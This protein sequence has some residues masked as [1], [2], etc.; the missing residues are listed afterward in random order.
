MVDLPELPVKL[1]RLE[2]MA[3]RLGG[4]P[5]QARPIEA[6]WEVIAQGGDLGFM[7]LEQLLA[8]PDWT[9]A[10]ATRLW[11][12]SV[13]QPPIKGA[14]RWKLAL[15]LA[16]L[17]PEFPPLL[18]QSAPLDSPLSEMLSGDTQKILQ[19]G[20]ANH[21]T[22]SEMFRRAGLPGKLPFIQ[23]A[24][25]DAASIFVQ[26][27]RA[28][29]QMAGASPESRQ[30]W[31]LGCLKPLEGDRVIDAVEILLRGI[32]ARDAAELPRM[33]NW[34]L[35]RA[36]GVSVDAQR[37]REEWQGIS[38]YD[39]LK[40]WTDARINVLCE[41]QAVQAVLSRARRTESLT[42]D[43][44]SAIDLYGRIQFWG[45]YA[46]RIKNVRAREEILLL[47]LGGVVVVEWL[48]SERGTGLIPPHLQ[49]HIFG[50][51]AI[52]TALVASYENSVLAHHE[53]WPQRLAE[54]IK[55][56]RVIPD[57]G[58]KQLAGV[59][60]DPRARR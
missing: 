49:P 7:E 12:I 23:I 50:E 58:L 1:T 2:A 57:D 14:L 29:G 21:R 41:G 20:W 56:W 47:D 24:G 38:L 43:E 48:A 13:W 28:R 40:R 4:P 10:R 45:H 5:G 30:D 17:A 6:L 15:A 18:I 39:S 8:A 54:A 32:G 53:G 59:P 34:V 52:S 35:E 33:L 27:F 60:V 44:K 22:P 25:R 31:L 36:S 51:Q 16:G 9:L 46:T 26:R 11:E 3:A 37:R 55:G 19:L 42:V